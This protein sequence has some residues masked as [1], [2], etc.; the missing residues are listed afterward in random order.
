MKLITKK[1]HALD[2]L[3]NSMKQLIF[4]VLGFPFF[5]F[6]Q[7]PKNYSETLAFLKNGEGIDSVYAEHEYTEIE[8]GY[9]VSRSASGQRNDTS[10]EALSQKLV[11]L[12]KDL[13][14]LGYKILV[15][16][17]AQLVEIYFFDTQEYIESQVVYQNEKPVQ[18]NVFDENQE[19]KYTLKYMDEIWLAYR[20]DGEWKLVDEQW[21]DFD[22]IR[23]LILRR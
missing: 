13:V 3:T 16:Y 5:S 11:F 23:A 9:R 6:S 14:E 7:T 21:K 22:M 17:Q 15:F 19:M 12:E 4:I 8:K 18:V 1:K 10:V 20:Y 2:L